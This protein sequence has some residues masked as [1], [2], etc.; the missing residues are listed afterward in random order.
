MCVCATLDTYILKHESWE[1]QKSQVLVS[2]VKPHKAVTSSTVSRW[3]KESLAI[4]EI[5]T[6]MF[7][8]H[9]THA[10]STTKVD[11]TGAL[12]V[13]KW[14]KNIGLNSLHFKSFT[15]EKLLIIVKLFK[16]WREVVTA[17][18]SIFKWNLELYKDAQCLQSNPE[19]TSEIWGNYLILLSNP[20]Q[21]KD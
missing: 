2:F 20:R 16:L 12:F 7:K 17:M 5:D 10:T 9:S 3:L 1:T 19:F 18:T 4:V 8:G 13:I 15:K 14:K 21:V 6:R 11:V